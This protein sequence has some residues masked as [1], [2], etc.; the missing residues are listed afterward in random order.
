MA[1]SS[2]VPGKCPKS[3]TEDTKA[4]ALQQWTSPYISIDGHPAVSDYPYGP[5]ISTSPQS[6]YKFRQPSH[7]GQLSLSRRGAV[8]HRACDA[9]GGNNRDL[10]PRSVS[11]GTEGLQRLESH[12]K[13][14][15]H[16][17]GRNDRELVRKLGTFSGVFVPTTLNVL[18]ILM[19]LRF[20]F[21]LGQGGILGTMGKTRFSLIL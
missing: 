10:L 2:V 8:E 4:K 14:A 16:I 7:N 6:M 3:S 9:H 12:D 18:S 21:I 15:K 1:Q 20:G 5:Q 19:F 13:K 11:L 17:V